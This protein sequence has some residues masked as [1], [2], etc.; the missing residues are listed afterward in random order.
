M[1]ARYST[2]LPSSTFAFWDRISKPVIPRKELEARISPSS[3]AFWKPRGDD[4]AGVLRQ[5]P[6]NL[7]YLGLMGSLRKIE[8][9]KQEVI[10]AGHSLDGVDLHAPIG[11][12]IGGDSPGEIAISIL[13]EVL[14]AKSAEK[15]QREPAEQAVL[16]G[17]A[18]SAAPSAT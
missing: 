18:P 4:L 2:I 10:E 5:E 15:A 7:C 14:Q 16:E 17:A 1:V 3:T 11:L 8:R 12:P 6:V 13:A 9:V